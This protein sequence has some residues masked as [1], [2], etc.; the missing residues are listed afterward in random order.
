MGQWYGGRYKVLEGVDK[1]GSTHV[2]PGDIIA[3]KSGAVILR[4][5]DCNAVQ[6]GH[7]KVLNSLASPSLDRPLQC[8]SG[9]CK[10]CGIWFTIS[11]GRAAKVEQP[12]RPT[13][14][15][16]EKLA[17]AGVK[18]PPKLKIEDK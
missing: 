9:H 2:K 14:K 12:E 18:A 15:I 8:G 1:L 13:R 17:N 11:N 4:C 7:A 3:H 10:K 6:F 5:P 16:P